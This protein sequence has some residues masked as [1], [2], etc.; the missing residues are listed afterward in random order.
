MLIPAMRSWWWSAAGFWLYAATLWVG[1]ALTLLGQR[2]PEQ[3]IGVAL[4]G[5][6]DAGLVVFSEGIH[7]AFGP[8]GATALVA[9]ICAYLLWIRK[10]PAQALGFALVVAAGWLASTLAKTIVARPRPSGAAL[11][12]AITE[13]GYNSYPSGHTAFAAAFVMAVTLVLARSRKA[14]AASL[15]VG[16]VFVA[17]VAFSRV[18]LGVHYVSDVIASVFVVIAA[19]M[20][21]GS[22]WNTFLAPRLSTGTRTES[23]VPV[24]EEMPRPADGLK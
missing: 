20:V 7:V 14:Q 24:S 18:Y 5:S 9:V 23:A 8:I 19:V 12:P 3:T 2:N 21:C 17:V 11:H 15:S 10:K 13:T 4:A 6:R 16:A 22:V 1:S